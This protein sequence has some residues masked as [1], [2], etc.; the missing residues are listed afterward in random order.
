MA[1]PHSGLDNTPTVSWSMKEV[2]TIR[3]VVLYLLRI[4][5]LHSIQFSLSSSVFYHP[6]HDNRMDDDAS[7][8]SKLTDTPILSQMSSTYLQLQIVWQLYPPNAVNTF[9]CDLHSVEETV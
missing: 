4:F 6:C 8:L 7:R 9:I 1:A 3:P 2:Y 5:A